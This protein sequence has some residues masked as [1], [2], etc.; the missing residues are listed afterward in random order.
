MLAGKQ[1]PGAL[2]VQA[3]STAIRNG[4]PVG[5]CVGPSGVQRLADDGGAVAA[6]MRLDEGGADRASAMVRDALPMVRA[7]GGIVPD[8][9]AHPGDQL[10]GMGKACHVADCRHQREGNDRLD[11]LVTG[12]GM[13]RVRIAFSGGQLLDLLV[14]ARQDGGQAVQVPQQELQI[15]VQAPGRGR[16]G[17]R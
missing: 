8:S 12:Q 7:P 1:Q 14:I 16:E 6:L 13:H 9:H 4:H 2:F 17:S 15:D 10:A 3:P 5:G 11:P